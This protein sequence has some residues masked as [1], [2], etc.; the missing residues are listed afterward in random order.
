MEKRGKSRKDGE[1]RHTFYKWPSCARP[2]ENVCSKLDSLL[3][4]VTPHMLV[5]Q[6]SSF[7]FITSTQFL[8]AP[9]LHLSS[10]TIS[11]FRSP[12]SDLFLS[13]LSLRASS[14]H[15]CIDRLH[16]DTHRDRRFSSSPFQRKYAFCSS[17]TRRDLPL[18]PSSLSSHHLHERS[19]STP[20]D[21]RATSR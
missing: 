9:F 4:N 15:N 13:P 12:N 10:L 21:T 17:S 3:Q 2:N 19:L 14:Q 8:F 18:V 5:L 11:V 20:S 16:I 6:E 1:C 7:T